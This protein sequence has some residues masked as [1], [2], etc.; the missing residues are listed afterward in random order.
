MELIIN[1]VTYIVSKKKISSKSN[2][3]TSLQ[4]TKKGQMFPILGTIIKESDDHLETAK[5]L[6]KNHSSSF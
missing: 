6:I 1:G 5:I 3:N 4:V 2:Y